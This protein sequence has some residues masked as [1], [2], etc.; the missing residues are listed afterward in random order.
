[1]GGAVVSACGYI[2]GPDLNPWFAVCVR[3]SSVS[4]R[5]IA[6]KRHVALTGKID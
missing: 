4:G 1:M 2:V 3:S 5:N 6:R